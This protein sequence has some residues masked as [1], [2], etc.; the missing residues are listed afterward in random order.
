MIFLASRARVVF[1]PPDRVFTLG[2]KEEGV[3][4]ASP[5]PGPKTDRG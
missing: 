2:C 4:Q 1:Q 5:I 3:M